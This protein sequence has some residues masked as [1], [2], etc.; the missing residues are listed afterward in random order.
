MLSTGYM[1]DLPRRRYQAKPVTTETVD[2][3][4]GKYR[5]L[6]NEPTP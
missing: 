2:E 5:L 6:P 4:T 3:S 1:S